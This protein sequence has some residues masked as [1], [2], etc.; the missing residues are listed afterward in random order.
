MKKIGRQDL[1]YE[2]DFRHTSL[3]EVEPGEEFMVETEDA[4]SGEYRT[5][6]DAAK[7]LEVWYLRHSPSMANPLTGPIYIKG[8]EPGDTVVITIVGIELDRQ[9]ATYWRPGHRPLGDSLRWG[10]LAQP[11]LV[12]ANLSNGT[13]DLTEALT[14]ED[15]N[16]LRHPLRLQLRQAPFIGTI[17]VAPEREVEASGMGQGS[18]GGNLDVRDICVGTKVYLPCSNKGGLLYIGDVHAG[19]GDTEIYGIA[20]EARSTVTLRCDVIKRQQYGFVRLEKPDSIISIASAKPLEEA[21][22]RA[23]LQLMEWLVQGY[24][25]SQREAYLLLGVNPDFKV[26]V[27]QMAAVGRLQFTA[28]AEI[29]KVTLPSRE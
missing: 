21:V 13:I 1:K 17:A 2:V 20:M 11:T 6:E 22:T 23:S 10:D 24:G 29:M 19:Q 12:I 5:P 9:G 8:A 3:L 25:C 27:Y 26:N 7:L 18:W 16:I 4:P 15:H 14:L 28:G